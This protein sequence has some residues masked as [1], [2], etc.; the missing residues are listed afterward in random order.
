M[1]KKQLRT[2]FES[3]EINEVIGEGGNGYVYRAHSDSNQFAIKI[4]KKSNKEKLRRFK[5]EYLFCANSNHPNII[6]AVDRGVDE[7]GSPFFVMPLF[8]GSL[9][10]L[11]GNL[12]EQRI[13]KIIE[14]IF[15]GVEAAHKFGV[16]HRDLKPENILLN[17]ENEEIVIADF[18]IAEFNE[19]EIYT[20]VDTAEGTR[21][22]NFQYAA[23][24]QRVRGK[25]VTKSA[26]I[27]ALGLIISELFTE[28]IP[29]GRN[30][31]TIT[32]SYPQYSYLDSIVEKMIQQNPSDR[33][34]EISEIKYEISIKANLFIAQQKISSLSNQVISSTS[35]DDLLIQDPMKIIDFD[36][37]EGL[38]TIKLNHEVNINWISAFQNMGNYTSVY[39]KGPES[40]RFNKDKAMINANPNEVQDVINYFKG[41]LPQV[42][43]V[44]EANLKR[45][46]QQ[47]EQR[48]REKIEKELRAEETRKMVLSS[49]KI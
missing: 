49:I 43:R 28:E 9:R 27:F 15:H 35:I 30:H 31:K 48:E 26:D 47:K 3:Y 44:Y 29:F 1:N 46:I 19:D 45:D 39:L 37:N 11:I 12:D 41:W 10:K 22:A 21:L 24:E 42:T 34:S 4:L 13:L 8:Q 40:F 16:I 32:S 5:N 33:Y 36:W 14:N 25:T 20:N 17:L 38:L 2:A 6:K 23:P 18:G 7:N